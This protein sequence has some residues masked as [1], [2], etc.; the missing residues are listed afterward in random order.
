[1]KKILLLGIVVL[2]SPGSLKHACGV[3]PAPQGSAFVARAG[4]AAIL[5][6]NNKN[7]IFVSPKLRYKKTSSVS[8]NVSD[9]VLAQQSG[10]N[11]LR[12]IQSRLCWADNWI[13]DKIMVTL[14]IERFVFVPLSIDKLALHRL[15][16][17]GGFSMVDNRVISARPNFVFNAAFFQRGNSTN[18]NPRAFY[19]SVKLVSAQLDLLSSK[20]ALSDSNGSQNGSKQDQIFSVPSNSLIRGNFYAFVGGLLL[21]LLYFLILLD[22]IKE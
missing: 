4:N 9:P 6:F 5:D 19:G 10:R 17:R 8:N 20:D 12:N 13:D 16:Y 15:N 2:L 1:M 7:K 22:W 21:G 14:H 11:D 18:K 3:V